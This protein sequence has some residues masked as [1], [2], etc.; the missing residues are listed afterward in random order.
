[1]C[2]GKCGNCDAYKPA[3]NNDIAVIHGVSMRLPACRWRNDENKNWEYGYYLIGLH[4]N[5]LYKVAE[6]STSD[7]ESA[8]YCE[9]LKHGT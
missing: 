6:G 7:I 3:T 1:M 8:L 9:V 5:G 4:P 2:C